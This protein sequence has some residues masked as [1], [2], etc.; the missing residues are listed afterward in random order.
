MSWDDWTQRRRGEAECKGV[1]CKHAR[2]HNTRVKQFVV[3]TDD[4]PRWSEHK[5]SK[6]DNTEFKT[7]ILFI[8]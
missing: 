6:V 3:S 2:S 4:K 5:P 8:D 1:R 7:E